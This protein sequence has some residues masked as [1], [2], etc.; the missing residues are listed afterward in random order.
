MDQSSGFPLILVWLALAALLGLTYGLSFLLSGPASLAIGMTIAFT[1]TALV[2]WYFVGL[3]HQPGLV[4]LA[5]WAAI[6]WLVILLLLMAP[7]YATRP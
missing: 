7:D 6:L 5:A 3:R 4:R 2:Y 1:K